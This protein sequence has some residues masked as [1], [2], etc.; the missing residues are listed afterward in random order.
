LPASSIN[1]HLPLLLLIFIFLP[2][3]KQ[4]LFPL[5]LSICCSHCHLSSTSAVL[6][7][8]SCPL[9]P[10]FP[11]ICRHCRHHC[12]FTA[13]YH[14]QC[15]LAVAANLAV[16]GLLSLPPLIVATVACLWQPLLPPWLLLI[17]VS[18]ICCLL[19]LLSFIFSFCCLHFLPLISICMRA[20][21]LLIL[22]NPKK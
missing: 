21:W 5:P 2:V 16:S 19:Q 8:A 15:L 1:M 18:T 9:A 11:L 13:S 14:R 4:L 20:G 17:T 3:H 6:A 7:I 22:F 10:L 12:L